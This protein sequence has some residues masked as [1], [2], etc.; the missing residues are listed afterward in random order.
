MELTKN[1]NNKKDTS[2]FQTEQWW[3]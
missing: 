2:F 3:Q 1:V